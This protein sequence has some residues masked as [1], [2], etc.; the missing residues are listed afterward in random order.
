MKGTV[1]RKTL[2]WGFL[3]VIALIANAFVG[4]AATLP[5]AAAT[6]DGSGINPQHFIN[7]TS[8]LKMSDDQRL[9]YVEGAF[10][11]LWFGYGAAKAGWNIDWVK[12]CLDSLT[13]K[14][15]RDATDQDAKDSAGVK[16]DGV[17]ASDNFGGASGTYG[18]L[19]N[20][21]KH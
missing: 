18:G 21:C 10:D 17:P 11:G 7:E 9:I 3:S 15:L 19:V 4:H 2:I 16:V 13:D 5:N 8:Y 12:K 14:A 1:H 20:V 6:D